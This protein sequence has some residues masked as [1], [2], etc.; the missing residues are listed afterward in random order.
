[1]RKNADSEVI[2][3]WV[4]LQGQAN[5]RQEKIKSTGAKKT[6]SPLFKERADYLTFDF[7]FDFFC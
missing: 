5:I 4:Y 7:T 1:L 3:E 6:P 2:C